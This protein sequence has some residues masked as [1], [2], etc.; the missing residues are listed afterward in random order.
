MQLGL[1]SEGTPT[2]SKTVALFPDSRGFGNFDWSYEDTEDDGHTED[3]GIEPIANLVDAGVFKR[4]L[5][6]LKE[7]PRCVLCSVCFKVGDKISISNNTLCEHQYHKDCILLWLKTKSN[8][9]P[10]CRAHY[11]RLPIPPP[12]QQ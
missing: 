11:T 1:D 12:V 9:C 8:E 7:Q 2:S 6:I 3:D 10:V 4:T 5:G